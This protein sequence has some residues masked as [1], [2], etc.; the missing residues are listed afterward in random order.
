MQN[1]KEKMNERYNLEK[2]KRD[3]KKKMTMETEGRGEKRL[4]D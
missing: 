4:E 2:Q 1:E 3:R